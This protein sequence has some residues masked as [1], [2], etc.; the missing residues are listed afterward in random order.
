M[1]ESASYASILN[2]KHP[3]IVIYL[4]GG[5]NGERCATLGCSSDFAEVHGR[6]KREREGRKR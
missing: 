5:C 6:R 2:I 4:A 1:S 3:F